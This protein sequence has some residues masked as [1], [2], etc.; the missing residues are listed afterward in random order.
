MRI[1]IGLQVSEPKSRE[2]WQVVWAFFRI[3]LG[4]RTGG[5]RALA[6][7]LPRFGRRF[8]ER[9]QAVAFAV[10]GDTVGVYFRKYPRLD[11]NVALCFHTC[12]GISLIRSKHG[13]PAIPVTRLVFNAHSVFV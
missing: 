8:L 1:E 3:L 10:V 13:K 6:G 5:D 9:S 11:D 2:L 4:K 12:Q 7:K